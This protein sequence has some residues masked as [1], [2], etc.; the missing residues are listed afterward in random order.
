MVVMVV[1]VVSH[2]ER[3]KSTK[4]SELFQ[5]LWHRVFHFISSMGWREMEQV[6][7]LLPATSK[8]DMGVCSF[9]KVG[10]SKCAILKHPPPPPLCPLTWHLVPTTPM[11]G[12]TIHTS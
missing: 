11:R 1:V 4:E 6:V 2:N 3:K 9:W 12:V 10:E 8:H 7:G 5:I